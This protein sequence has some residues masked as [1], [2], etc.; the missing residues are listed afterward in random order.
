[1]DQLPMASEREWVV[2]SLNPGIQRVTDR[3]VAAIFLWAFPRWIRPNHLTL[4]RF[5][6]IP[7]VLVLLALNLDWW[8]LG[9]FIAATCTDFIDGAMARTR[10]QIT[11]LGT[12]IDPIADKLLVAAI[13]AYVGHDYLV[14]RIMLVFI[15]LELILT[16]LGARVLLR[17]RRARP[18]NAYGKAKM[19]FQSVALYL[20]LLGGILEYQTWMKIGSYLLWPALGLALLSGLRQIRGVLLAK[21]PGPD[22]A[23]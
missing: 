14:V 4:V 19:V 5:A 13:L 2:E 21:D 9:V 8:G 16:A 1:M 6:L 22:Q 17:T 7:V 15:G 11:V 23:A 12:Y 10:D 18:A 20:F 3:T